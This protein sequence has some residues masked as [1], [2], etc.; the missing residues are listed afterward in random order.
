VNF[1]EFPFNFIPNY[2]SELFLAKDI[3]SSSVN[4]LCLSV[5]GAVHAAGRQAAVQAAVSGHQFFSSCAAVTFRK[6]QADKYLRIASDCLV[7]VQLS[8][9]GL[10]AAGCCRCCTDVCLG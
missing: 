7:S 10:S 5:F 3:F 6:L 4:V 2:L 1:T 8:T 9:S